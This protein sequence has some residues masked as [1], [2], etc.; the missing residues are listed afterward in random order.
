MS[1]FL[2]ATISSITLLAQTPPNPPAPAPPA[3]AAAEKLHFATGMTPGAVRLIE[4]KGRQ[5][6]SMKV[7][8]GSIQRE[9]RPHAELHY[10]VVVQ[11]PAQANGFAVSNALRMDLLPTY[12][13]AVRDRRYKLI[14][15]DPCHDELYDLA[16]DPLELTDLLRSPLGPEATAA[17]QTL[18]ARLDALH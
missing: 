17:Y 10:Q 11:D 12:M 9:M 8:V 4:V 14:R 3:P 1:P 2:C 18:S 16:R 5:S 13:R 15:W 6:G 7:A